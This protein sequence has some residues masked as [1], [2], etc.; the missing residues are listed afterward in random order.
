MLF[1]ILMFLGIVV[2]ILAASALP[3]ILLKLVL[4]AFGLNPPFLALW[5]GWVL[6]SIVIHV[7]RG[8]K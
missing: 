1:A 8:G 5:A 4:L 2:S 3:A 6:F 7:L